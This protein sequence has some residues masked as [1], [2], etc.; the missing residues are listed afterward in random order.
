MT[1]G[2]LVAEAPHGLHGADIRLD[3]PSVGATENVLTRRGP[4]PG[5]TRLENAAREPEIVDIA[6]LLDSMGAR[7]SGAGTSVIEVEGVAALTPT[8]HAVVPDR[9]AAGTWAFAAAT[10]RGDVEVVGASGRPPQRGP[11]RAGATRA[12]TVTD[13]ADGASGSAS[14]GRRPRP[15][16]SRR[17]PT[18]GSPPTCSR[19]RWPTTRSPVA[20]P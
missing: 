11:R 4:R 18:P 6:E 9:I 17:C 19:S 10:T 8:E 13:D 7:I 16:T 15:S 2:Y 12:P 3:F 20:A 1:H 14:W 5:H